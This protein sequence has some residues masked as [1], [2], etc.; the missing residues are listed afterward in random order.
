M[1]MYDFDEIIE[2][3]GTD[4]VKYDLLRER[5]GSDDLL[6]LWVADM[7]FRTP[8]FITGAIRERCGHPVFGYTFASEAYY[9]SI[10]DWYGALHGWQPEREWLSFIPGIVRGIAFAVACFTQ[11]GD[12]VIIQPPVYHPFRIVPSRMRREVALNPLRITDGVYRMD[13]DHLESIIDSRCKL[14]IL[15]S[16]H[17]P[18]GIVWSRDTLQRLAAICAAHGILVVSDEIHSEMIYPGYTHHP[19]PSVSDE[20]AGCSIT[21]AAPSKTFNIAGLV[22]SYAIV[23]DERIRRTFYG[24]LEAGEFNEGS[25][26][27]YTA[28]TAAYT[29]GAEW[30]RRMLDY[31]IGNVAFT[32]DYLKRFLPGIK[33]YLPQASFLVWLDC[34]SLGLRQDELTA[35]VCRQAH[36]ALNDGLIFGA[37]GTGYLRINVGCPRSL[38]EKALERLL[39]VSSE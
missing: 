21:F 32:D 17:N 11:E 4:C 16:P 6:P 27:S 12:K 19:F 39:L 15:S 25:L 14:L 38:L 8:D 34:R 18:A 30:R 24:Y 10:I 29:H 1:K 36:L 22:A 3:R 20:A 2:R 31:V 37:E 26:F 13:F 28:T 33:A 35:R 9:R 7:D 5:F 23:P